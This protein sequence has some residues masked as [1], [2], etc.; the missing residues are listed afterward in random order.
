MGI[1]IGIGNYIG[2]SKI[3]SSGGGITIDNVIIAEDSSYI[4]T[5]NGLYIGIELTD[6]SLKLDRGKLDINVLK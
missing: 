3:A 4:I 6:K 5:E 2:K 1:F